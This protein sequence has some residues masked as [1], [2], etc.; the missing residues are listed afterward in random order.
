MTKNKFYLCFVFL[1]CAVFA[2]IIY[3]LILLNKKNKIKTCEA[4]VYFTISSLNDS[5]TFDGHVLFDMSNNSGYVSLS[6]KIV[7]G[8]ES[9]YLSQ[10]IAFDYMA[11]G[12][13]RY[14][15]LPGDKIDNRYG[16]IPD[17]LIIP[18]YDIMGLSGKSPI[19]IFTRNR[20]YIVWG[21]LN[22]PVMTC[23]FTMDR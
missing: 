4:N 11:D 21:T 23:V 3:L 13:G 22:S 18:I 10:D 19:F 1:F 6:G 2:L 16:S 17:D 7:D 8:D 9:Y 15:I 5:Y 12:E 20:D 14:K